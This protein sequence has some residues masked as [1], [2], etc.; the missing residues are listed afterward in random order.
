MTKKT[1]KLPADITKRPMRMA[2]RDRIFAIL[3]DPAVRVP[4]GLF[5][6]RHF[7]KDAVIGW[8]RIADSSNQET[9]GIDKFYVIKKGRRIIGYFGAGQDTD[10]PER[11]GRWELGYFLDPRYHG[12]GIIP[13]ILTDF[14]RQARRGGLVKEFYGAVKPDNQASQRVLEKLGFV[15]NGVDDQ[16]APFKIERDGSYKKCAVPRKRM[17]VFELAL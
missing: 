16:W 3:S 1:I 15:P 7:T 6:E 4:F 9:T 11:E 10:H 2:D 17:Q 5:N 8:C 13:G 14:I 12:Q